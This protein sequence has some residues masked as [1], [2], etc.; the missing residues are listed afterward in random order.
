MLRVG[1]S[2]NSYRLIQ[3]VPL[4]SRSIRSEIQTIPPGSQYFWHQ[5]YRSWELQEGA[6]PE[7]TNGS[8][9]AKGG[10]VRLNHTFSSALH[11]T[12]T[13]AY[14]TFHEAAKLERRRWITK[15][16]VLPKYMGGWVRGESTRIYI[17]ALHRTWRGM[18]WPLKVRSSR[19]LSGKPDHDT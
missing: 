11:W 16:S 8:S 14:R 10:S 17:S 7:N 2:L 3:S 12:R 1:L 6:Y 15:R 9:W 4:T 13:R 18:G 19:F 5:P